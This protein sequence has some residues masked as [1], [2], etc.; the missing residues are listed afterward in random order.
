MLTAS[1]PA[2]PFATVL[3]GWRRLCRAYP[4]MLLFAAILAWTCV[5][6]LPFL[7][8]LHDDEGFYSAVAS[9]WLRG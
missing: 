6:R 9:R 2:L 7:H 4:N 3:T 1:T 8:V 5:A